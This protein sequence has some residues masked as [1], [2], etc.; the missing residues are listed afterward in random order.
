M[1]KQKKPAAKK[2]VNAKL[3]QAKPA[4]PKAAT[5]PKPHRAVDDDYVAPDTYK[6]YGNGSKRSR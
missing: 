3:A 6:Y 5:S 2:T 1:T 4:S